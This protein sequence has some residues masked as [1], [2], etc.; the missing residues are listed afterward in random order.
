[1]HRYF[2]VLEGLPLEISKRS[3]S[4]IATPRDPCRREQ[5]TSPPRKIAEYRSRAGS[6]LA[7]C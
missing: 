1:M 4:A 6:T 3:A 2:S 7:R 5:A